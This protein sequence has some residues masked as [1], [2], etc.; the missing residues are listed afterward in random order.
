MWLPLERPLLGTWP[1]T[2]ACALTG[3][4]T[5][6]PLVCGPALN[7]LSYTGQGRFLKKRLIGQVLSVAEKLWV[8]QGTDTKGVNK[9]PTCELP[10]WPSHLLC[11]P[12]ALSPAIRSSVV[13]THRFLLG[14]EN[15]HFLGSN[16]WLWEWCRHLYISMAQENH[17]NIPTSPHA[18]W[19]SGAESKE[20][21]NDL[22][23]LGVDLAWSLINTLLPWL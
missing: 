7:P 16:F 6:N 8:A 14:W 2:Q 11:L 22:W 1:T 21:A 4:R 19:I 10:P 15:V 9:L 5:G 18:G 20:R 13:L 12:P 23:C 3:N 17:S